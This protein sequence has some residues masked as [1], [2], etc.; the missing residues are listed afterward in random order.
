MGFVKTN[1]II[2]G[3]TVAEQMRRAEEILKTKVI[4]QQRQYEKIKRTHSTT[5]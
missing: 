3:I 1:K 2:T 5:G 4:P